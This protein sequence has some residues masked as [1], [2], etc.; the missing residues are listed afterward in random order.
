MMTTTKMTRRER[1]QRIANW[2]IANDEILYGHGYA[3]TEA[4]KQAEAALKI[5]VSVT[6]M[7]RV[8]LEMKSTGR[9]KDLLWLEGWGNRRRLSTREEYSPKEWSA[10]T[11]WLMRNEV[12]NRHRTP[13]AIA[14]RINECL[15]FHVS[16]YAVN[17]ALILIG[18]KE[19][20]GE[21]KA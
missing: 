19:R 8:I 3:T 10:I 2:I 21:R 13:I 16:L 14:R 9:A 17:E 12:N 20:P 4:A 18:W 6:R 1:D 7:R 15:R 5:P 11:D